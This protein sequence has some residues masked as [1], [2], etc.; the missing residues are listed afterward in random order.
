M[1]D[2]QGNNLYR[3]KGNDIVPADGGFVYPGFDKPL[4][5]K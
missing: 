5:G 2:K 3:K 4:R 1:K